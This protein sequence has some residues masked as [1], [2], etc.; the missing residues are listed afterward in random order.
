MFGRVGTDRLPMALRMILHLCTQ[1]VLS[2]LSGLFK[3]KKG[4]KLEG[5]DVRDGVGG[6]I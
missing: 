4:L 3:K 6:K 2:V 5:R 1:A